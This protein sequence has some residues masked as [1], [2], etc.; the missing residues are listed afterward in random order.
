M[1]FQ[2]EAIYKFINMKVGALF[3]DMGTGKTKTI[4]DIYK[5]KNI[6]NKI[7]YIAPFS[8]LENCKSEVEKW[9]ASFNSQIEWFSC[10]SLGC[11]DIIFSRLNKIID[12]SFLIIDE[13]IKFKN[14][15]SKRV[16]RLLKISHRAAYRFILNGTP[17]SRS[18][19]DL[20]AQMNILSPKI[21]NMS[22]A[23]FAYRFLIFKID[24]KKAPWRCWSKPS[25]E[26][27]LMSLIEPYVFNASFNFDK[28]ILKKD[29]NF[30]LSYDENQD[31][32][33]LKIEKLKL[34]NIDFLAFA[35]ILQHFYTFNKAKKQEL[36]KLLKDDIST[37]Y[38]IKYLQ[39]NE[40]FYDFDVGFYNGHNK[41]KFNKQN[42]I[43]TYG[44]GAFGLNLQKYKRIVFVDSTF[45]YGQQ[46]QAKSRIIRM[47]Q[48]SNVSIVNM[49]TNTGL[50][51][52]IKTSI[53]KKIGTSQNINK[54]LQE[55]KKEELMQ[56]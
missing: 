50:E 43:I 39:W 13:S 37:L 19:L 11:S 10:E 27:K 16:K 51:K 12:N 22:E 20:L 24:G 56:L 34:E 33:D 29:I 17:I 52:I 2:I 28:Q 47:G 46:I 15:N 38:F 4:I 9:H 48:D 36:I 18:I 1:N 6:D 55:M 31:Y 41:Q 30:D 26:K 44:C 25:N 32:M 53:E 14:L 45:D 5:S 35:Q 40:F 42:M 3:M 54:I 8:T 23:E 49:W 7:I 21:L